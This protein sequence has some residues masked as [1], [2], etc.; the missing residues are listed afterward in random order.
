M[1]S[2]QTLEECA[3]TRMA[4]EVWE[5]THGPGAER[6]CGKCKEH[7]PDHEFYDLASWCKQC[8]RAYAREY[9]RQRRDE[10]ASAVPIGL[11]RA[12]MSRTDYH[13]L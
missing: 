8:M 7:K 12:R 6:R 11:R 13:T 3:A 5:M 4:A 2:D 10:R 1:D 9:A